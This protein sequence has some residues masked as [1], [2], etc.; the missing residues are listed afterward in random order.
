MVIEFSD[1]RVC[2]F[3]ARNPAPSFIQIEHIPHDRILDQE[4]PAYPDVI[5]ALALSG[6]VEEVLLRI[7]AAQ[8]YTLRYLDVP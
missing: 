5:G 1:G 4:R 8:G 2:V 6:P 7:R 3:D